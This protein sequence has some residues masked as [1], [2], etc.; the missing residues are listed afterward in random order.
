MTD[1]D[2]NYTIREVVKPPE[3]TKGSGW[4]KEDGEM[5]IYDYPEK[6]LVVIPMDIGWWQDGEKSAFR[7][8]CKRSQTHRT[9]R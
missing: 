5:V 7:F 9:N 1:D 2:Q 8:W 6:Y 3:R 4:K